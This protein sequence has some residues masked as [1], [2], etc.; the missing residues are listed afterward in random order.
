MDKIRFLIDT[1]ILIQLEDQI[2]TDA[3]AKFHKLCNE[4]SAMIYFHPLSREEIENDSD[5]QRKKETLSKIDKYTQL[6]DP[7]LDDKTQLE[8]L[9][10]EIKK[11]ND[12]IDCQ[13]LYALY[14]N[15]ISFLVTE[16]TGVHQRAKKQDLKNKVLTINQANNMLERLF[17]QLIEI[18]LPKIENPP[19]Y[20]IKCNDPLFKSLKDEYTDFA[21]WFKKCS[22]EQVKA[23]TIKSIE[24]ENKLEAICIYKEANEEDYKKYKLPERS[25]KLATFKVAE[26]YRGKKLG[27]LMLKQAFL[28]TITN[29]FQACWM[30]VFPKHEI[31]IDFIKDFGFVEIGNTNRRDKKTNETE[32][33]FLK[34]C[35]KPKNYPVNGLDFHIKYSPH[36]D[37]RKNIEKY[38]VPIKEKYHKILFPEHEELFT[39]TSDIQYCFPG[40]SNTTKDIPGH[41]IKKMYLCH[42]PTKQL[43][44]NDLLF[45]YVSSPIKS[46]CSVGIVE[47]TFRSNK[48][49][50][51]VSY[52]GKR[53][54][55]SFAEIKKMAEKKV[56]VIAFRFIKHLKTPLNLQVLKTQ[57]I[58]KGAPQSIQQIKNYAQLKK[59]IC[60]QVIAE[61]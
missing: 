50:E 2:V 61:S 29:N 45:F 31:L 16:D 22:E 6:E 4:H 54:V 8:S 60:Q 13:L 17:P 14:K 53:S 52:V 3:F 20:K 19:L 9:F 48:L 28:Y 10:G 32:L 37:D 57:K 12:E 27:E 18:S 55:Y 41:T 59:C 23:W 7:P 1:N 34:E 24:N 49:D 46:V 35:V 44:R 40:M 21:E 15:S 25:L 11:S 39:S 42:A 36:Y 51:V 33:V 58:I 47:S 56:L 5:Q 38:I 26:P 30:T 43:K